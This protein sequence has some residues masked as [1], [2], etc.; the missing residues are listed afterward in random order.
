MVEK[1]DNG[2]IKHSLALRAKYRLRKTRVPPM[3]VVP[4]PKNRGGD[5]VKSLRT[6]QLTASIAEGYDT[7]E[8]NSNAVAVEDKPPVVAGTNTFFFQSAFEKQVIP[9]PDMAA[10]G[11]GIMA[12]MGSLSHSHLNCINRNIL[13]GKRGCNCVGRKTCFC[14]SKVIFDDEGNLNLDRVRAHDEAW[15]QDCVAGLEWEVLS[16]KLDVEESDGALIISIARNKKTK[17]Q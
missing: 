6:M 11:V 3:L 4:H 12:T 8:A 1:C 16:H 2:I 9:D 17:W 10:K 5:A 14:K 13:C 15:A 7:I